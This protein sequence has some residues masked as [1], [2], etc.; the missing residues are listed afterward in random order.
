VKAGTEKAEALEDAD[1]EQE[2]IVK[3]KRG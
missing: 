3:Q 2:Q 1:V